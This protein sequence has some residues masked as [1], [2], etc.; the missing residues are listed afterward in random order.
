MRDR[1]WNNSA[2]LQLLIITALFVLMLVFA[3]LR[4]APQTEVSHDPDSTGPTGLAALRLWLE[5]MG[6]QV[7][8]TN[9]RRFELPDEANLLFI[10]PNAEPYSPFDAVIL[11]RWVAGGGT[12]VLIGPTPRE[13]ALIDAFGVRPGA[14]AGFGGNVRQAQPLLPEG[15]AEWLHLGQ[16]NTLDLEDAPQAISVLVTSGGNP[17]V[18]VQSVGEGTVWHL[19]PDF[20]LTNNGLRD[21]HQAAL[22]PALLRQVPP[23]GLVVIDTYHL[24]GTGAEESTID[25][26]QAWLYGTPTGWATLFA[27]AVVLLYL[28][29]QGNRLGPPLPVTA[30]QRPREAA[31]Y[32]TAM[33]ALQ[34]RAHLRNAVVRHHKHRLKAGLGRIYQIGPDLP[35]DEFVRRLQDVARPHTPEE[36]AELRRLLMALDDNI[37]ENNLVRLV[38]Q[39]D[40]VLEQS[41]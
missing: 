29:L 32:V 37:G 23:Q 30:G 28:F 4:G 12:L 8:R 18:A 27:L 19:S 2:R 13:S 21:E 3:L 10:Y 36:S 20:A 16:G 26:L 22:V 24:F 15:E 31:E 35:D 25:T 14:P 40:Q 33:A 7:E 41:N 34:R 17:Q 9:N 1:F 6:Y 38:A 11:Y 39:I 5:E